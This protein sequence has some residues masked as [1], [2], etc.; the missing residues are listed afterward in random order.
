MS[1]W[2]CGRLETREMLRTMDLRRCELERA[3]DAAARSCSPSCVKSPTLK[4]RLCNEVTF[5]LYNGPFHIH[6]LVCLGGFTSISDLLLCDPRDIA[7]RS[8]LGV[9]EISA[10]IRKACQESAAP[11][12]LLQQQQQQLNEASESIFTT[13]D[14][15]LDDVLGGGIRTGMVWECAGERCDGQLAVNFGW[16]S[17]LGSFSVPRA[18]LNWLCNYPCPCNCLELKAVFPALRVT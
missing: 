18:N 10:I 2:S 12:S 11:V 1:R 9:S 3:R 15:G 13:G 14:P 4:R 17:L 16:T 8:R 7:K 6:S 5:L